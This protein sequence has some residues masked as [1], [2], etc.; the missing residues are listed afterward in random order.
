MQPEFCSREKLLYY[1]MRQ[2]NE[3]PTPNNYYLDSDSDSDS[4]HEYKILVQT[5]K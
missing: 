5:H 3:K 4:E 1:F 2:Q